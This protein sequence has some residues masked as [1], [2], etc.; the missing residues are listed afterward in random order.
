[1]TQKP[2][3]WDFKGVFTRTD[4]ALEKRLRERDAYSTIV[5]GIL[6]Q[7]PRL[8][9]NDSPPNITQMPRPRLSNEPSVDEIIAAYP[10]LKSE[11]KIYDDGHYWQI[12]VGGV[13]QGTDYN[14]SIIRDTNGYH[15]G[16]MLY[17]IS[18]KF[19]GKKLPELFGYGDEILNGIPLELALDIAVATLSKD[20]TRLKAAVESIDYTVIFAA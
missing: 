13:R 5:A 17:E 3:H 18:V 19:D 10:A 16:R 12:D 20:K 6:G 11:I 4:S 7:I 14:V 15:N 9:Q 2:G 8:Y 1:M